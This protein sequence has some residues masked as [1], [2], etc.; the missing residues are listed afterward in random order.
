MLLVH[1][2]LSVLLVGPCCW[3]RLLLSV[4]L[5]SPC[6]SEC[7]VNGPMLPELSVDGPMLIFRITTS[8]HITP[9]LYSLHW[10][11]IEQRIKYKLSLL[12]FKISSLSSHLPFRTSP[13][14]SFPAA[15]LFCRHPS[16]QNAI[17]VDWSACSEPQLVRCCVVA[18]TDWNACSATSAM[19]WKNDFA[20][21]CSMT[22]RK[23]LLETTKAV[24]VIF[25]LL[26]CRLDLLGER[27]FWTHLDGGM[28]MHTHTHLHVCTHTHTHAHTFGDGDSSV[29]RAPDS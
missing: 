12:C 8:A 29:V 20:K 16:V 28:D 5:I 11:H 24:S 22:F 27:S 3:S 6:C 19:V 7:S 17:C 23:K 15:Q 14:H 2:A 9:M 25:L 18:G 1:V 13:L 10:L 4:L 26:L 21:R